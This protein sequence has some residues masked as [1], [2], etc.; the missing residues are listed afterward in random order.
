MASIFPCILVH[1]KSQWHVSWHHWRIQIQWTKASH[2]AWRQCM[3]NHSS[4]KVKHRQIKCTPG[5]VQYWVMKPQCFYYFSSRREAANCTSVWT[6]QNLQVLRWNLPK[7][8]LPKSKP[9]NTFGNCNM[10]S[11]HQLTRC[12]PSKSRTSRTQWKNISDTAV[13]Y[14]LWK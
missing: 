11:S 10:N 4:S 13:R 2:Q 14:S 6:L 8:D 1:T 9:R 7:K 3:C 12:L 5:K